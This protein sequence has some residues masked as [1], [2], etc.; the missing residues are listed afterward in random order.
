MRNLT[1]RELL[2]LGSAAA[3]AELGL[4]GCGVSNLVQSAVTGCSKITDIEHVIILTQENRSFDHYF[5]SYR[6]VRGFSDSSNAFQ[7]PDPSNTTVSPVGTLLPF[8]LDTSQ[9]NAA[10][11]HDITH[12]WV[13]QHQSW[14]NGKMDGFVTSRLPINSNDAL[15]TMGYYTR[16]DIPYYYA[17]ADAFTLCDNYFCSVIGPTDPNRLYTMA[18]S[19]DPDGKNGG[20]ILQTIVSN[21]SA[22]YGR[23]TYTT[24]PEQLQARGISW[25]VYSTPDE[26]ILGGIL[27]DNVLSYFKNFQDPSSPLHQNAFGPQFPADFLSDVASGNLPQVSW[28]IGSILTSEHP[29]APSLFGESFL[30]LII[31]AL[32]ANP[33]LWAK[34]VL[35]VNYDENGGFFDHV[36]PVTAPPGTP[37]EY[38]TAPAVPDPT[39]IGSPAI[40]GPI[41][42][43]F[44]VPM[45]IISPFSRGGFVSSDLFDHTSV[46]RFLETRFGAEVPNLSAWRRATVG[47]LT[48]A[49]NFKGLDLSI[50]NLPST[51]QGD[52]Q[53]IT[54]CESSLAG[55]VPYKLPS[56]QALPTQESGSP[57]R[58]SGTC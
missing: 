31:A 30:S 3:L 47:D 44:R 13:P 54:Q 21:R 34:T 22:M 26:S 2:Q 51:I 23:L 45:L 25:K 24:M 49:F 20:P 57:T 8:H 11:T 28:L 5:G 12:D 43:G 39:V 14:D 9:S 10:C 15:L 37:G 7:Q 53:A 40:T 4:H 58:P 36:P 32:M 46:L 41:G 27:S 16:A 52:T 38:V 55:F 29:P 19:L 50:P 17:V 33:L 48:T 35:F 42:L 6:G 18:A 1:R 56:T